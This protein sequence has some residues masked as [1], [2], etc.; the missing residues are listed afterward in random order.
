MKVLMINGSP[1]ANSNTGIALG[2]ME[3][4]FAKYGIE[5]EVISIGNLD[6]RGCVSCG[7]CYKNGRCAFDD[8]VN[9]VAAKFKTCDGLVVGSPVYY[10]SANGTVAHIVKLFF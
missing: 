3:Q 1:R 5:T 4:V 7:Y 9:E 2:E 8:L 10:A 6:I